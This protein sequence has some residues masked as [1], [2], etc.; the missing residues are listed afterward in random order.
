MTVDAA[1]LAASTAEPVEWA[2]ANAATRLAHRLYLGIFHDST[3]LSFTGAAAVSVTPAPLA[4]VEAPT[5]CAAGR[6]LL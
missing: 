4:T 3:G 5:E 6:V 1:F 2:A